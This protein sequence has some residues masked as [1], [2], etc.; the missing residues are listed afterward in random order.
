M[1]GGREGRRGEGW[2]GGVTVITY[3]NIIQ[4]HNHVTYYVITQD[5]VYAAQQWY[6]DSVSHRLKSQ[7]WSPN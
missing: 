2:R 5:G 7:S 1:E 6:V 3:S 4:W